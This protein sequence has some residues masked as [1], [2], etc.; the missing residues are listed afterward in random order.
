MTIFERA[1]QIAENKMT[2]IFE[3]FDKTNK[4]VIEYVA[5]FGA[6]GIEQNVIWDLYTEW[7]EM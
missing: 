2:G 6:F 3:F 4:D 1:K 5:L 7:Q